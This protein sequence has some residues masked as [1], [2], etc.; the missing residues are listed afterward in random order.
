[1]ALA[2]LIANDT[3][4]DRLL[5]GGFSGSAALCFRAARRRDRAQGTRYAAGT[6]RRS[7][8]S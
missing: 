4:A 2:H 3:P 8:R 7:A 6:A 1:M 5:F